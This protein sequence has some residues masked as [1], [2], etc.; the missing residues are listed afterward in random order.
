MLF[1]AI[2]R[3]IIRTG[4]LRLIDDSGR[5]HDYGEGQAPQITDPE[6]NS[7][8]IHVRSTALAVFSHDRQ[9]RYIARALSENSFRRSPGLKS[10]TMLRK[11]L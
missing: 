1:A 11:A 8:H 5:I 4:S 6:P 3:T 10:E 7:P 2:L 9:M